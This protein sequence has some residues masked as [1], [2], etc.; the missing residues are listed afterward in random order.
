M[1]TKEQAIFK[2]MTKDYDKASQRSL[3]EYTEGVLNEIEKLVPDNLQKYRVEQINKQDIAIV[4][5]VLK[6]RKRAINKELS[7]I[8]QLYNL[9]NI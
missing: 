6:S 5:E 3:Y 2:K 4:I 1:T 8:R 9:N 7:F